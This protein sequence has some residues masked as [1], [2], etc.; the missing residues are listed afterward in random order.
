MKN[1]TRRGCRYLGFVHV[2]MNSDVLIHDM[3]AG[4]EQHEL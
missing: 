2:N 3:E 1:R 4:C